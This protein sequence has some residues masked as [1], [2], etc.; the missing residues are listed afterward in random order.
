MARPGHQQR[1]LM[2]RHRAAAA[3]LAARMRMPRLRHSPDMCK[4]SLLNVDS[5]THRMH[6]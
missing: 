2:V 3:A 1:M 4:S 5:T 6:K